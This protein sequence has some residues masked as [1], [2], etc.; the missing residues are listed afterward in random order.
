MANRP[1]L[2][3]ILED[4][5]TYTILVDD[6]NGGRYFDMQPNEIEIF[7]NDWRDQHLPNAES[8]MTE[9][10]LMTKAELYACL[11]CLELWSE[12]DLRNDPK[13][14]RCI[15]SSIAKLTALADQMHF[16]TRLDTDVL[17]I[18]LIANQ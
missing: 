4:D 16:Q 12:H 13:D 1:P 10:K 2:N 3:L 7:L 6:Q 11:M 15:E 9:T 17:S 8:K 5:G 18:H 14:R